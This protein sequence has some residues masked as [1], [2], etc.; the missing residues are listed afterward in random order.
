MENLYWFYD[1]CVIGILIIAVYC[2]AKK[3][4]MKSVVMTVL[5]IASFVVSW[6]AAEAV[7][8]FVY[9]KF[10]K[11]TIVEGFMKSADDFCIDLQG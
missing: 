3:G 2:G 7:G 1:V 9:D 10:V 8:P 5:I 6:F 4:L 11:D